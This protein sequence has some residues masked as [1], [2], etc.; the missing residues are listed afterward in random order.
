MRTA[1]W[2]TAP[3]TALRHCAREAAGKDR[4]CVILVIGC[5]HA[6]EHIFFQR[7]SASQVKLSA[8]HETV[9]P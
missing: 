4:R 2:E 6:I 1:A 3:Q 7:V 5:M 8:S 9:S